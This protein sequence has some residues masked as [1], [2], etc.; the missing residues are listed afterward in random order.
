MGTNLSES[1]DSRMGTPCIQALSNYGVSC[2][3]CLRLL[4]SWLPVAAFDPGYAECKHARAYG[5]RSEVYV[6]VRHHLILLV[7]V[8]RCIRIHGWRC[9]LPHPD[10]P[11]LALEGT[12][13]RAMVRWNS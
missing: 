1:N 4:G 2:W 3:E 13:V 5:V 11:G 8:C 12:G 6:V 9:Y 10:E 7:N